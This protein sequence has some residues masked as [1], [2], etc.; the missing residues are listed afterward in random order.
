MLPLLSE[1]FALTG[2]R[3]RVLLALSLVAILNGGIN[4]LLVAIITSALHGT[5]NWSAVTLAGGFVLASLLFL[6]TEGFLQTKVSVL[7]EHSAAII[8][9]RVVHAINMADLQTGEKTPYHAKQTAIGRDSGILS[10]AMASLLAFVSS[11]ATV[12]GGAIYMVV[13][14][15]LAALAFCAVIGLTVVMYQ[16]LSGSLMGELRKA[17][18][19]NDQFFRFSEDLIHGQKEL[20]LDR[21]WAGDFMRDDVMGT[22]SR[23]A[24]ELAEVKSRQMRV[25]QLATVAFL[26]LIG[27]A[28]FLGH[29]YAA[30]DKE[31]AMGFVLTLL[32]LQVPIHNAVVRLPA[33]GEAIVAM[34][35][36]TGLIKE[37]GVRTE[38]RTA[39]SAGKKPESLPVWRQLRLRSIGFT[40]D[41]ADERGRMVLKG[42]DLAVQRGD[43]VFIVGG[44]GSGKTTL[45]KIISGLYRP[46]EGEL[47][48][49]DERI[50]HDQ[51]LRYRQQ[52]TAV[53][54]DV[55]LFS[56]DV[57]RMSPDV[58][59][60]VESMLQDLELRPSKTAD[61]RW[62]PRALS[63]GQKK[64]LALAYAMGHDRPIL[65]FDEW[66][67]D[68]DPEFRAYFY[69]TFLPR[70]QKLGKTVFVI[71]H[72]DRYFD[73]ADLLV[74]LERGVLREV[75]RRTEAATP[76]VL[77]MAQAASA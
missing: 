1:Y 27:T 68:Q 66:T 14:S 73:R 62:D 8:R 77:T 38:E 52:I 57:A 58:A 16:W 59:R 26:A 51:L 17:Y 30:I 11:L 7:G 75:S 56:R 25:G 20:K 49:D 9:R 64:R 71:S 23:S 61:G 55:H 46:T 29:F 32:F 63:Q 12:V 41:P 43:L 67:A 48:L 6:A 54:S 40:Y 28:T 50:G 19:V 72:D 76:V 53:F 42:I 5:S 4:I 69:D 70:L 21:R 13:L 24:R 10:G 35:R 31:I 45:A 3:A 39:H 44:N 60:R 47:W 36:I 18:D 15:P 22:L 74:K 34:R 2:M 65:F 33:L 37:L